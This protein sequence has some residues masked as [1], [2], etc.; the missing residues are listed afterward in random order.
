MS[1]PVRINLVPHK[2]T[3]GGISRDIEVIEETLRFLV[4]GR[5]PDLD[6][7]LFYRGWRVRKPRTRVHG[8]LAGLEHRIRKL[9][10]RLRR[11]PIFDLNLHLERIGAA[12]LGSARTEA[13]IP[14]PEWFLEEDLDGLRSIDCVLCK[15]QHA[16][17]I[18]EER[19]MPAR[20]IGFTSRDLGPP[21]DLSD[22]EPHFLHV[23]GKSSEKG[24]TAVVRAWR[25][26]PEWPTLT[27]VQ[28]PK[29]YFGVEAG[30]T[31]ERAT[32]SI[33]RRWTG[34]SRR[35][36]PSRAADGKRWP[37]G[38]ERLSSPNA[39]PSGRVWSTSWTMSAGRTR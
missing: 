15:T 33:P 16:R 36:W 26:H 3:G 7:R 34:R 37:S 30:G 29:R 24:T 28:S 5:R 23:A 14:N 18:F 21:S 19:G 32:S 10:W 39:A 20:W 27:L 2:D 4:G 6:V 12:Y 9:G 1:R 11:R 13:L 31:W 22:V 35:F 38:G 25:R 8:W 17:T